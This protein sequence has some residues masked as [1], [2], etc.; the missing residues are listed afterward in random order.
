MAGPVG[1]KLKQGNRSGNGRPCDAANHHGRLQYCA[2]NPIM[3]ATARL[4]VQ[5]ADA[6]AP[7]CAG[8]QRLQHVRLGS[9]RG[10]KDNCLAGKG[11]AL[12][13]G[14]LGCLCDS[15]SRQAGVELLSCTCVQHP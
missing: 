2:L 15:T 10:A 1:T 14:V 11:T 4:A 7:V 5:H 8:G 3:L 6:H 12:V 9:A 13:A